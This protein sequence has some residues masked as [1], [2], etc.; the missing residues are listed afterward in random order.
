GSCAGICPGR[1]GWRH[2]IGPDGRRHWRRHGGSDGHRWCC[3]CASERGHLNGRWGV[4][5][6]P[7][8]RNEQYLPRGGNMLMRAIFCAAFALLGAT[9][10]FAAGSSV[11]S[12]PATASVLGT[13]IFYD[14]QGGVDKH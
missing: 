7:D 4:E 8:G 10:A 3:A 13:D 5:H 1:H 12:M 6:S 11:P 2:W 14:D 9:T